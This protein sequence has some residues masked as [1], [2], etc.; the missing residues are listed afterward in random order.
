MLLSAAPR[1]HPLRFLKDITCFNN[2]SS[3]CREK[4]LKLCFFN[5]ICYPKLRLLYVWFGWRVGEK[6]WVNST[7][8]WCLCGPQPS[9]KYN[10]WPSVSRRWRLGGDGGPAGQLWGMWGWNIWPSAG[11]R[12]PVKRMKTVLFYFIRTFGTPLTYSLNGIKREVILWKNC[13]KA[14]EVL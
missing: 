7:A 9:L 13:R 3:S 2:F 10:L 12:P 8:L 5:L 11:L 14:A 1:G 6:L 4:H